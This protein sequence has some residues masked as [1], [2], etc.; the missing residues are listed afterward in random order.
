MV[1]NGL[2]TSSMT[3]GKEVLVI[4]KNRT[5]APAATWEDEIKTQ[6]STSS[7]WLY[8]MQHFF[9]SIKKDSQVEIGNSNDALQL[10]SIIDN[11]YEQKQF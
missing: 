1:L 3:Y 5:T 6:Y 2:I 10:M 9:D 8:E 4:S 7:S 11:I